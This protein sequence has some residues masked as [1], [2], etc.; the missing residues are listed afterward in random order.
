M[1]SDRWLKVVN[2]LLLLALLVQGITGLALMRFH[3][4]AV[5]AVHEVG[6]I[7]FLVIAAVHLFLNRRWFRAAYRRRP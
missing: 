7:A 3:V 1:R 2:P 4:E 5:E 6:G